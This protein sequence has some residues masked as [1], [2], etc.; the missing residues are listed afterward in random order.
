MITHNTTQ[1][2]YA[3]TV[4]TARCQQIGHNIQR[5]KCVQPRWRR[6]KKVGA[7]R[8][9]LFGIKVTTDLKTGERKF[10]KGSQG[11]G[12]PAHGDL[13]IADDGIHGPDM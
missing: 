12:S 3:A 8:S 2:L 5:H 13:N 4:Y 11:S 7:A 6:H 9:G 10:Q 1:R